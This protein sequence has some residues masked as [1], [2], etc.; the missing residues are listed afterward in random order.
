LCGALQSRLVAPTWSTIG[1]ARWRRPAAPVQVKATAVAMTGL[2]AVATL[3]SLARARL[4]LSAFYPIKA[5]VLFGLIMLLAIG[6][7][8]GRHPFA[9]FGPANRLTTVRAALVALLA[10]LIGESGAPLV[11]ATATG[12]AAACLDGLDGWLAR[13]TQMTS[14]FGA[15]FDLETDALLTLVLAALAWQYDKAGAWVLLSGLLRYLFVAA[16]WLW[17]WIERPLPPSRRRQ[18]ICVVQIVGLIL[19]IA[20]PIAPPLSGVMAAVALLALCWSF[21]VDL[22]WLRRHAGP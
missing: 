20:P 4:E 6:L 14:P 17:T 22:L 12:S 13:R 9:H 7:L 1:L 11:A 21:S 2:A 8:Q 18:A 15:R 16:G 3:A 19:V 10:G 5:A